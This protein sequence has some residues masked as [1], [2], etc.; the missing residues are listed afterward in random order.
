MKILL[1]DG[2]CGICK[3]IIHRLVEKNLVA[4]KELFAI[5]S[6]RDLDN[7][8]NLYKFNLTK[9]EEMILIKNFEFFK[10]YFAF[11]EIF[12]SSKSVLRL[13]FLLPF[14]DF[15][16]PLCYTY[17]ARHRHKFSKNSNCGLE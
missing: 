9:F 4:H 2:N 5:K 12:I 7:F 11:K 3:V 13:L 10:G 14:S 16:G 8:N 1:Y 15:I 17:F 6:K